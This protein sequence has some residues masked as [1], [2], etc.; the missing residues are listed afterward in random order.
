MELVCFISL[1]FPLLIAAADGGGSFCAPWFMFAIRWVD[2]VYFILFVCCDG[3][4]AVH[5]FVLTVCECLY[6]ISGRSLHLKF[7][8]K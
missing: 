8:Y 1:F 7:M 6:N 5:I 4:V 3:S 2:A